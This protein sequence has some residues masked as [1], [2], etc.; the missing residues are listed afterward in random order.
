M[1]QRLS[2][3]VVRRS[4]PRVALA[5]AK[6]TFAQPSSADRANIV[7]IPAA[8]SSEDGHFAPRTGMS[9]VYLLRCYS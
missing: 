4:N 5:G 8:Y 9:F 2:R 3:T 1:L 6:R 7:D